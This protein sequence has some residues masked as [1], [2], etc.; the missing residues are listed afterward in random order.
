MNVPGRIILSR[1]DALGDAVVTMT[2][3]GWI[4][5]HAPGTHI[6]VLIKRYTLDVWRQCAHADAILV[7]E[8]L[9]AMGEAGAVQALKT[10]GAEAIVHAFPHQQVAR[11]AKLAGIA[12]RIGTSHRW[13][14]WT[15]CNER[16]SFSRK[17]SELH[18]AQLNIKLL[19]P[20]GIEVP[21]TIS[22]LVPHI[23][24]NAP[25][26]SAEVRALFRAD[27][28]NVILHPL[29]GS[30]VGWGLANFAALIAALDPA[31][32]H[33]LITGTAAEAQRYRPSLPLGSG[34]VTDVGGE[35]S[36]HQLI[37]LIG[38]CDAFVSASTGPLHVAAASGIRAIGLFSM[39]RPIFP[40][41]WAPI[42]RDAHALTFDP[43]CVRCA[44]GEACECIQR[45][46]PER[47]VALLNGPGV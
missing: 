20:F 2:T 22:A 18:E 46:S 24:Y 45:I 40:A 5:H 27:R 44:R 38:A 28:R 16:V 3:A 26:P 25:V 15:T 11:W 17:R 47:V 43:R 30:G 29:L 31:R 10:M 33:V 37:E 21:A 14:H 35:L 12:R 4:K 8:D 39:R 6:T 36:L 41:R 9:E 42:G 34:H 7:L 19:R 23:G 32:Y 1:P 13:W